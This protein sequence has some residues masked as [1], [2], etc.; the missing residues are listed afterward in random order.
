MPSPPPFPPLPGSNG[1]P[2]FTFLNPLPRLWYDPPTVDGFRISIDAGAFTEVR[3]PSMFSNLAILVGGVVVDSDLDAGESY[4]FGSNVGSFDI[5][6]I[7][8]LLDPNAPGF[9]TAF[10]LWLDFSG[11]PT[12]MQWQALMIPEAPTITMVMLGLAALG[13]SARRKSTA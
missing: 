2:T 12:S 13:F 10:P 1:Q 8:P 6:G 5:V 3:A 7:R 9:S 4:F 11:T